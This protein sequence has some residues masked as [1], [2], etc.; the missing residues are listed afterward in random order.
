MYY[1]KNIVFDRSIFVE[2][3]LTT[4]PAAGVITQFQDVPQLRGSFV[5]GIEAFTDAQLTKTPTQNTVF[6]AAAA[7][8]MLMTFVQGQ[9]NKY[10]NVPYYTLISSLNGGL[11]REFRDLQ[12]NINKSSVFIGGSTAIQNTSLAFVIY[13]TKAPIFAKKP[14]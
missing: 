8:E 2:L 3:K 9:E 6:A 11:I 4:A 10:E 7:K 1:Y 14:C 5:Q 13:Y 12:I